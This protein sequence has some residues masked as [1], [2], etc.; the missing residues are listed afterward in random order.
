M[1]TFAG[2]IPFSIIG[3]VLLSVW[4]RYKP[5]H[6]FG[7]IPMIVAF[8]LYTTLDENSSNAAWACFQLLC[9][10]GEGCLAGITV[11]AVQVPL[12]EKDVSITTGLWGFTCNFGAIWGV[13]IPSAVFNNECAKHAH[14]SSDVAV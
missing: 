3:G 9:P 5:L 6:I 1:P 11:P 13:T 7:F 10:V 14:V 4:G 12:E 2:I 8:G